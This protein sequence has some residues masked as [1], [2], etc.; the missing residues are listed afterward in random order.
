MNE[1]EKINLIEALQQNED[2]QL[3]YKIQRGKTLSKLY[4][5]L[6]TEIKQKEDKPKKVKEI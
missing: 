2:L 4:E 6:I 5:E 1:E 3:Y